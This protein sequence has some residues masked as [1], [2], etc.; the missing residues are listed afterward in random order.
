[1]I[2]AGIDE[3]GLGPRL[4]P[5][6]CGAAALR[7]PERMPP[8]GPWGALAA[9]VAER[10]VAREERPVVCDSKLL[11][12]R[13]G[14]AGLARSIGAFLAAWNSPPNAPAATAERDRLLARLG[15]ADTVRYLEAYPWHAAGGAWPACPPCPALAEAL[16]P[17]GLQVAALT[18]RLLLPG[19]L[20]DGIAC[21]RNKGEV[22]LDQTGALLTALAA[23]FP[24]EALRVT[25]DK[26][27]GRAY[28]HPFLSRLFPG[29]WIDILEER[30]QQSAYRIRRAGAPVEVT[31]R[32]KAD[33]SAFCTA[34]ASILCKYVRELF[35]ADL[36]AWFGARLPGL[37]PTA[38]YAADAKRWLA[39]AAPVLAAEGIDR[40][41][42]VRQR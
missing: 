30:P 20:N 27:G 1:M 36:N 19:M 35:M 37:R 15:A 29:A 28:Y 10:P 32:A 7:A 39:E 34:L 6:L 24:A 3:A 9:A 40:R 18:V 41:C 5:L 26:Q 25:I 17:A 23:D 14:L 33:Q 42:L 16:A 8:E 22:L 11:H 38:G 13:L 31:F 21:G 12:G 4:G 2:L